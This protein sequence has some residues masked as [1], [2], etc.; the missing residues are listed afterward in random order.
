ME[1]SAAPEAL[2]GTHLDLFPSVSGFEHQRSLA[3]I[4]IRPGVGR[5]VLSSV[6]HVEGVLLKAS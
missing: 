4:V 3:V 2:E 6:V 5:T 1:Q